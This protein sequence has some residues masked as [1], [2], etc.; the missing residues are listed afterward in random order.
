MHIK[1]GNNS[2]RYNNFICTRNW[3]FQCCDDNTNGRERSCMSWCSHTGWCQS[4]VSSLDRLC[5]HKLKKRPQSELNRSMDQMDEYKKKKCFQ[6]KQYWFLSSCETFF[7]NIQH[8]RS[9]IKSCQMKNIDSL[10]Y[11]INETRNSQKTFFINYS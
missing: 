7:K 6:R 9:Q 3:S 1:E 4:P 2:T 5:G 8:S 10:Q 11:H